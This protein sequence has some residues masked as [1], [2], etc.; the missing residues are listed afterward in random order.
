[1]GRGKSK[2]FYEGKV[3]H[4]NSE[5]FLEL[6][7]QIYGDDIECGVKDLKEKIADFYNISNQNRNREDTSIGKSRIYAWKDGRGTPNDIDIVKAMADAFSVDI[8]ALIKCENDDSDDYDDIS[9]E[10]EV[11]YSNPLNIIEKVILSYKRSYYYNYISE[12]NDEDGKEYY[13]EM[14]S[15]AIR[16][17]IWYDSINPSVCSRRFELCKELKNFVDSYEGPDGLGKYFFDINPKLCYYCSPFKIIEESMY[18]FV[19]SGY[20]YLFIPSYK[21]ILEREEYFKKMHIAFPDDDEDDL[22]MR[23]LLKTVKEIYN[24]EK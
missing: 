1:M 16:S 13:G 11:D 22:F 3:Y 12:T 7:E 17:I 2:Y 14:L 19:T 6:F 4:F 5:G 18:F 24:G 9:L 15:K 20:K 10:K 8:K 21:Q 23:E